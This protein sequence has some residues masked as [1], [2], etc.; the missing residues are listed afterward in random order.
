M[1]IYYNVNL[2]LIIGKPNPF[3]IPQIQY[4]TSIKDMDRRFPGPKLVLATG[5]GL[6]YGLSKELLLKWGG[7]PRCCVVFIDSSDVGTLAADLRMKY[8]N[9]PVIATITKVLIIIIYDIIIL[10]YNDK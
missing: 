8:S 4:L 7:D 9:P 2:I 6:T 10:Y 3:E 5:N 1:L